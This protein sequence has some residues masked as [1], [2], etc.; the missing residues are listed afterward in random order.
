MIRTVGIGLSLVALVGVGVDLAGAAPVSGVT[1][2][3]GTTNGFGPGLAALTDGVVGG[4]NWITTPTL[5]WVDGGWNLNPAI[6]L[7]QN[8]PQPLLTFNLDGTYALNSVTV[9]YVVDHIAGDDTRNLRAPDSMT[10]SFSTTGVGGPFGNPIVETA[11]WDDSVDSN[12]SAGNSGDGDER[13][14]TINLGGAAANAVQ[15]DFR[16]NAEWLFMSEI[17]FDG[18]IVPEPGTLGL[19]GLGM[20]L[21]GV[22]RRRSRAPA[23]VRT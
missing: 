14:L 6:S 19:A 9:H 16:T 3:S 8:V 23:R 5:G 4:N 11:G 7:D 18:S 12:P 2:A 1:V 20:L 10:A 22:S 15:L 13:S 17:S 21:V